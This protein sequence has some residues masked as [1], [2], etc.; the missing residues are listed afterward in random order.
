MIV[1]RFTSFTEN[2]VICC[3]QDTQMV[4]SKYCITSAFLARI[5]CHL[6]PFAYFAI[7]TLRKVR[8]IRCVFDTTFLGGSESDSR[9]VHSLLLCTRFSAKSSNHSGRAPNKFPCTGSISLLYHPLIF[10]NCA[11]GLP[12]LD[13]VYLDVVWSL[14]LT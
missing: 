4:C 11:T 9:E 6:D 14:D 13:W 1:S 2:F 10:Q 8:K 12:V 5:F 3:Y 7:T